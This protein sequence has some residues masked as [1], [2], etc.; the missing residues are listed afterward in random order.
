[1]LPVF[2]LMTGVLYLVAGAARLG[3]IATFLSQPILTG[4]LNG[5]ALIIV[6]GQL[7][8]LLGYPGAAKEFVPQ[9][10]EVV[11]TIGL[12]HPPTA[13]LGLTLL[14]GLLVL[15]RIAPA[16]PGALVAVVAGIARGR[17]L[18][19]TGAGRGR[20]RRTAERAA[21][22]TLRSPRARRVPQPVA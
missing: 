1:M 21:R 9:L 12:S 5:I 11:E 16:V 3:F 6:V 19:S 2:T 22:A 17:G 14:A 10:Q 15:G 4:Y 8:K 18:R 13:L 7:P 20:D